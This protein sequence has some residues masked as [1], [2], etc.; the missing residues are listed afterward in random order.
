MRDQ[1]GLANQDFFRFLQLRHHINNII[2]KQDLDKFCS[3]SGI[4]GVFISAYKA[5]HGLKTIS[6]LYKGL[7]GLSEGNIKEKWEKEGNSV[8]SMDE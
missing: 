5:E 4:L 8:L 7:Q 1:H 3:E 6:K 2:K